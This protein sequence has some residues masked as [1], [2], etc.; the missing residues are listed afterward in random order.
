MA[1]ARDIAGITVP[2]AAGVAAGTAM[3]SPTLFLHP[4]IP[5]VTSLLLAGSVITAAIVFDRRTSDAKAR[6]AFAGV[7]LLA[8]IFCSLNSALASGIPSPEGPLSRLAAS[9][10]GKLRTTIDAIPYPAE[11]TAPLVKA[12]LTGDRSELGRETEGIFRS[13]G[14]SHILALSGLH[15]GIIY[16]MLTR[17]LTP[18]GNSPGARKAKSVF[19]LA[20]SGFYTLM[21][22]ASPSI[23]RAFL[24]ILLNEI[25]KM[26]GREREPA[27]I[28]MAAL[29]VQLAVSPGI[30]HSPGFQLSYLAVAGIILVYPRLKK[31]YPD[32]GSVFW[33][34]VDPIKRIWN[35]AAMSISCQ[36]FTSPL[37]W[38]RFH[39]F[40]KYFLITNL[41]ALPLTSAIMVLSTATIVL[42]VSGICPQFLVNLNDQAI[43]LLVF[44]LQII[45]SL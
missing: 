34:R 1:E 39:T 26:Q 24:F 36:L 2:F 41:I 17:A 43:G 7:F 3:C 38:Y 42:S 11:T 18:L 30:I 25:A 20:V 37:A 44:C 8:G 15:L 12:L 4:V 40:P 45:S 23:V 28:F 5:S 19:I 27:R 16:L 10:I 22:G 13:S 14:A 32:S 9:C 29:T 21:T 31:L 35:A 6:L 33:N